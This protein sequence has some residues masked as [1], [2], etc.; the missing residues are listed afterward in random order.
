MRPI[1]LVLSAFGP[2]SGETVLNMDALGDRG[3]Y[4]ITGDTG[5]GK[6]TI[7]DAIAFAL[8]G[9]ASGDGRK[10]AMLRSQYA[11]SDVPTFVELTFLHA[12]REYVV[13]RSPEYLRPLKRGEGM[14]QQTSEVQLTLPD[15][16][17]L[18]RVRD[19]SEAVKEILGVD[20][21]QFSQIAM[22]AQGDF[23]KL[24]L[25]ETR[26][27]QAIFRDLFRTARYK[28]LE[29]RLK[30]ETHALERR[31]NEDRHDLSAILAGVVP[32]ADGEETRREWER[33]LKGE[34]GF[35]ETEEILLR[36]LRE[37]ERR[38]AENA[39][40]RASL[41]REI[42]LTSSR[43][44]FARETL[45]NR[46]EKAAAE[47]ALG[48]SEARREKAAAAL[49]GEKAKE[50]ENARLSREAALLEEEIPRYAALEK[51]L[52]E[53]TGEE[54]LEKKALRE[55]DAKKA[56]AEDLSRRVEKAKEELL[57]LSRAGEEREKLRREELLFAE[58]EKRLLALEDAEKKAAAV[59]NDYEKAQKAYLASAGRA[60]TLG[61]R[62]ARL[63]RVFRDEQA[64]LMA[65]TLKEG[66][67]C[68][69]CG[70]VHHPRK[71]GKSEEAPSEAQVKEAEDASA[72]AEKEA[73]EKSAAAAAL[74]GRK[75][76]AEGLLA[77]RRGEFPGKETALI[78]EELKREGAALSARVEK[79]EA[80][81]ARRKA[82]EE[83]MPRAE[84]MLKALTEEALKAERQAEA[85][86]IT[87]RELEK[88]IKEARETLRH[89]S[90]RE[91][92]ERRKELQGEI[93]ARERARK[94]AEAA[95]REEELAAESLRAKLST[96]EELLRGREE[97]DPHAEE[98]KEKALK[99]EREALLASD[100]QDHADLETDRRALSL[101]RKT[102]EALARDEETWQS[103]RA[104]SDTAAGTVPGKEKIALETY[105]QAAFFDR[106]VRRANLR[107]LEMSEGQYELT[108]RVSSANR[109]SQTGLELDVID[110]YNGSERSVYTLS[111]GETFL[112][113]LAL[114]LGLSD[115]I[116]SGAGGIQLDTLF[117]DEGFGSLDEN[118]LREAV[119]TLRRLGEGRRLVGIISHVADLKDQIDLR[120]EVT[121]SPAGGSRARITGF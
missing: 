31:M 58:K 108:R 77:E 48:E 7:F 53:K 81:E 117:I 23:R 97:I 107:L 119:R 93:A 12:G 24:L 22:I 3:L 75:E 50:G 56:R 110:H 118:A 100:R 85:H 6:T 27:R 70:S 94:A 71:A 39:G 104:L 11:S 69:V 67:P 112:A 103:A 76:E 80:A 116:Q 86:G 113:S 83:S 34:T 72:A 52:G 79:A 61:E 106:I 16:R 54:E 44:A 25:A 20:R 78:R 41:D 121:K 92:E 42:A 74:R 111:G 36:F 99:T 37:G 46:E 15:G 65:E 2:Y 55:K 59:G 21:D 19:V 115:E 9:E 35:P 95:L 90:L 5:A 89:P 87:A 30:E 120:I 26:E 17:V 114:A 63:R 18:T 98:E 32:L 64:G 57:S 49:E 40:K 45:K 102:A 101:F 1:K 4:L 96:L 13:R 10:S 14:R 28:T 62:A 73:S 88:R 109:I 33:C 84:T 68:P 105:V 29:E 43:L 47:K 38:E 82:V 60:E 8:Y 66:E 51:L 91:A